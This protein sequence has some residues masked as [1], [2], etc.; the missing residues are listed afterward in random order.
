MS[1]DGAGRTVRLQL[2]GL[3]ETTAAVSTGTVLTALLTGAVP[4]DSRLVWPLVVLALGFLAYDI[5]VRA[6][7]RRAE[8]AEENP[9]I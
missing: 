8:K 5:G 6:V 1:R 4:P 9:T 7:R 3:P 2:P